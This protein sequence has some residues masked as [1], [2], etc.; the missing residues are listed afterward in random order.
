MKNLY[1]L[2]AIIL[3]LLLRPAPAVAAQELV[4]QINAYRAANKL[5]YLRENSSLNASAMLKAC[6]MRDNDYFSHADLRGANSWHLFI[7]NGYRY[8]YAG[9]NLAKN[10][11]DDAIIAAAFMASPMHRAI[12]LKPAYR[13]IGVGKCGVYTAVHFGRK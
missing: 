1:F 11:S 10:Y 13:D 9:E 6:D 4:R 12:M 5:P 2:I 8:R 3:L 7:E